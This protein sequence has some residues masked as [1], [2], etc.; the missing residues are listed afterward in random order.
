[1]TLDIFAD[2][3]VSILVVDDEEIALSLVGQLLARIGFENID[4][5]HNGLVAW[6]MMKAKKYGLVISDWN[7]PEMN[8][9]DLLKAL[10]TDERYR[11]IRYVMTS[12]DGSMERQDRPPGRRERVPPEAVR[13]VE[14][15]GQ[16]GGGPVRLASKRRAA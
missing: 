4:K 2:S 5:A 14:V 1:M 3:T 9:L 12:I 15:A 6:D 7:M 13:R 8:G 16:A 11:R 10:P